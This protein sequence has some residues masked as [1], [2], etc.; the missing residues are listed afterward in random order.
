MR[1][2]RVLRKLLVLK[3]NYLN[4]NFKSKK[5]SMHKLNTMQQLDPLKDK[6][7]YLTKREHNGKI[8]IVTW[9]NCLKS[10]RKGIRKKWMGKRSKYKI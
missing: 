5:C 9:R 3:N 10:Y 1:E 8:N 4:I 6:R 2:T 7:R